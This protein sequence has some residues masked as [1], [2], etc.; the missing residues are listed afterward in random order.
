MAKVLP[1]GTC[2]QNNCRNTSVRKLTY[3]QHVPVMVDNSASDTPDPPVEDDSHESPNEDNNHRNAPLPIEKFISDNHARVPFANG[4][5]NNDSM[6][7]NSLE[8]SAHSSLNDNSQREKETISSDIKNTSRDVYNASQTLIASTG[9]EN[10]NCIAVARISSKGSPVTLLPKTT[11][12]TQAGVSSID[13]VRLLPHSCVTQKDLTSPLNY[14]REQISVLPQGCASELDAQ[15]NYNSKEK[16]IVEGVVNNGTVTVNIIENEEDATSNTS[17]KPLS[18]TRN[19]KIDAEHSSKISNASK[20]LLLPTSEACLVVQDMQQVTV[21]QDTQNH[22]ASA[23]SQFPTQVSTT[24]SSPPQMVTF[25]VQ[26][27]DK[28]STSNKGQK[29]V[30]LQCGN[31][32]PGTIQLVPPIADNSQLTYVTPSLSGVPIMST[33]VPPPILHGGKIMKM[34]NSSPLLLLPSQPIIAPVPQPPRL[35]PIAPKPCACKLISTSQSQISSLGGSSTV[36]NSTS[37][38]QASP[39]RKEGIQVSSRIPAKSKRFAPLEKCDSKPTKRSRTDCDSTLSTESKV[40]PLNNLQPLDQTQKSVTVNQVEISNEQ[41]QDLQEISTSSLTGLV[42]SAGIMDCDEEDPLGNIMDIRVDMPCDIAENIRGDA[43]ESSSPADDRL[44]E[45]LRSIESDPRSCDFSPPSSPGATSENFVKPIKEAESQEH[46]DVE[47]HVTDVHTGDDEVTQVTTNESTSTEDKVASLQ[48]PEESAA[49]EELTH[50]GCAVS[51]RVSTDNSLSSSSY[52]ITALCLSSR[53]AQDVES[54]LEN[55]SAHSIPTS[56]NNFAGELPDGF[57]EAHTSITSSVVTGSLTRVSTPLILPTIIYSSATTPLLSRENLPKAS[58]APSICQLPLPSALPPPSIFHRSASVLSSSA[59]THP[60]ALPPLPVPH[61][62]SLSAD[63]YSSGILSSASISLTT[64]DSSN[65]SKPMAI[66]NTMPHMSMPSMFTTAGTVPISI[67]SPSIP[68]SLSTSLSTS[69][70]SHSISLPSSSVSASLLLSA[71]VLASP[72]VPTSLSSVAAASQSSEPMSLASALSVAH[73]SSDHVAHSSSDPVAHSSSDLVAHSSPDLVA[74]SSADPVANSS[75][76]PVAHSSAD[77]VPHSSSDPVTHSSSDPIALPTSAPLSLSSSSVPASLSSSLPNTLAPL[78]LSLSSSP[79]APV[80]LSSSI[81]LSFSSTALSHSSS[82]SLTHVSSPLS[83]SGPV[84]LSSPLSLTHASS[85]PVSLSSGSISLSSSVPL[86]LPSASH[87]LPSSV[88]MSLSSSYQMV[89]PATFSFSLTAPSTT[90]SWL[91]PCSTTVPPVTTC[92][93]PVFSSPSTLPLSTSSIFSASFLQSLSSTNTYTP[94]PLSN[95]AQDALSLLPGGTSTASSLLS[96]SSSTYTTSAAPQTLPSMPSLC[97]DPYGLDNFPHASAMFPALGNKVH[98]SGKSSSLGSSYSAALSHFP[99]VS[100]SSLDIVSACTLPVVS[101]LASSL[102]PAL[103]QIKSVLGMEEENSVKPVI[104]KKKTSESIIPTSNENSVSHSATQIIAVTL[105]SL[106]NPSLPTHQPEA[107]SISHIKSDA[108]GLVSEKCEPEGC[109]PGT[110]IGQ[111]SLSSSSLPLTGEGDKKTLGV[112]F[113]E[114]HPKSLSKLFTVDHTPDSISHTAIDSS[115]GSLPSIIPQEQTTFTTQVQDKEV[116]DKMQE[117]QNKIPTAVSKVNEHSNSVSRSP[118]SVSLVDAANTQTMLHLNRDTVEQLVQ[119]SKGETVMKEELQKDQ[120][121]NKEKPLA[122]DYSTHTIQHIS[123]SDKKRTTSDTHFQEIQNCSQKEAEQSTHKTRDEN[124]IHL[125]KVG[126]ISVSVD[127]EQLQ[128]SSEKQQPSALNSPH[129]A[130]N[131]LTVQQPK[132]LSSLQAP[133][134]SSHS[135]AVISSQSSHLVF[136]QQL[137]VTNT[138]Q[139]NTQASTN[140]IQYPSI[141]HDQVV[142]SPRHERDTLSQQIPLGAHSKPISSLQQ[143]SQQQHQQQQHN[144]QQHHQTQE[145]VGSQRS[146]ANSQTIT[147]QTHSQHPQSIVKYQ[148]SHKQGPQ[149][150]SS[151]TQQQQ[152]QQHNNNNNNNNNNN[153]KT[154]AATTATPTTTETAAATTAAA[155]TS[156]TAATTTTTTATTAAAAATTAT[157]TTA[158][159]AAA[160]TASTASTSRTSQ[161]ATACHSIS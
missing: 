156:T 34:M 91:S 119:N 103:P 77:P 51:S 15:R 70:S 41:G 112:K 117:A 118:S 22:P 69:L 84:S 27:G 89:S 26:G 11:D 66:S 160:T 35:K 32:G 33:G 135:A 137:S 71:P 38:I 127:G 114:A 4:H 113:T 129:E 95:T 40:N 37:K 1:T 90:T 159:T 87:T 49:P 152:Q 19:A 120:E 99:E 8:N 45:M 60:L 58:S 107:S 88:S 155:T 82:I 14:V 17:D 24:Y 158:A 147:P 96:C 81:P 153:K 72:S 126:N 74:H 21:Q 145:T 124:V 12:A 62:P 104:N 143:H 86:S 31:P 139:Q 55:I 76:D 61:L 106:S 133:E 16:I 148:T 68:I 115:V 79:P 57:S 154:A 39:S 161:N 78:P 28:V 105:D 93:A 138:H 128:P 23:M 5:D 48:T 63:H 44:V 10:N 157:T 56:N 121:G 73:S 43:M 150:P 132:Q 140:T 122:S 29:V 92:C 47:D 136:G 80:S 134:T 100:S 25:Q 123:E 109:V 64:A 146:P 9:Q 6:A 46:D 3:G 65:T 102:M 142:T 151:N 85:V 98:D 94:S 141:K 130:D 42:H 75:T 67:P 108:A 101:S 20:D 2:V 59:H 54:P 83:S 116:Q 110:S 36:M 50:L 53:P 7:Q 144:H 149:Q 111:G 18:L 30:L 131:P 13:P 97:P 52:S 125:K